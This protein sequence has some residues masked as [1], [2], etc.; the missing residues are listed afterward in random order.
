MRGG[1]G[2]G[3]PL[4]L[5]LVAVVMDRAEERR[6]ALLGILGQP[7]AH[8][9][10]RHRAAVAVEVDREALAQQL[11]AVLTPALGVVEGRHRLVHLEG[12]EGAAGWG[13]NR[14]ESSV[15]AVRRR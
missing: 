14:R 6:L 9:G 10:V 1:G 8:R 2:G 4:E 3:A 5:L 11:V 13:E 12:R 7:L 15:G